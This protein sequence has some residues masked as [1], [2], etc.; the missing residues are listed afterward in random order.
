MIGR[1]CTTGFVAQ[2]CTDGGGRI[3]S[4]ENFGIAVD[5][6]LSRT[7]RTRQART[8]EAR[9]QAEVNRS[10]ELRE[11]KRGINKSICGR[12]PN[13]S[14]AQIFGFLRRFHEQYGK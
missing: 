7:R 8:T 1:P 6:E 4:R 14:N 10:R 2:K 11:A 12:R 13:R 9:S 3:G 5:R